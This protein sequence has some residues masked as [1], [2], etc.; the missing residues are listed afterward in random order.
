MVEMALALSLVVLAQV[1]PAPGLEYFPSGYFMVS[2]RPGLE[3][4]VLTVWPGPSG[5]LVL[6]RSGAL[7]EEE[8]V[9]VLVGGASFHDPLLLPAYLEGIASASPRVR[10]AAAYGYRELLADAS[11]APT[12][13]VDLEAAR[14][15]QAEMESVALTLRDHSLV[16]LWLTA[17]LANDGRQMPGW[18]GVVLRRAA[19]GCGGALD[20]LLVPEDLGLILTAYQLI[21]SPQSR[22]FLM[23]F[24]E[25]LSLEKFI[26]RPR[27]PDQG[28]NPGS[29]DAAEGRLRAWL[30]GQCRSDD[31]TP[32]G[33]RVSAIARTR[34]RPFA[35]EACGAWQ[36]VLLHGERIW[37]PAAARQLYRCGGPPVFLSM[38]R[39][40]LQQNKD[41][42][43]FLLGWFRVASD[44]P[45]R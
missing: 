23:A 33:G 43:A 40:D 6:W 42:R 35:A 21:E 4:Q 12:T 29:Y 16:E 15:L 5:L 30:E 39:T 28:W 18:S 24:I 11:V 31:P 41:Q 37:W 34:V 14:A 38:L 17:M 13:V 36:Q 9:A 45:R 8:Q 44:P 22:A 20:R 32:L 26:L 10:L 2:A 19:P 25:G 27:T 1:L 7:D 3:Q